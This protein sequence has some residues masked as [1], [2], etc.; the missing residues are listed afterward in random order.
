MYCRKCGRAIPSD[1]NFCPHCGN[2]VQFVQ[3]KSDL[4]DETSIKQ[5]V[6]G[7]FLSPHGRISREPIV[8]YRANL[9]AT[10]FNF[11]IR[12][13]YA[14]FCLPSIPARLDPSTALQIEHYPTQ[15]AE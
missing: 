12:E 7:V 11:G 14:N 15:V 10:L 3:D 9:E 6:I 13:S 1:S 8:D 2:E 5:D 4:I